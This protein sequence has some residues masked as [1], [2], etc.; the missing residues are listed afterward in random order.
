VSEHERPIAIHASGLGKKFDIYGHPSDL[1]KEVLT[2]RQRHSEYWALREITFDVLQG[3]VVG[4]IGKNGAGKSTLLKILTGTLEKT[5]GELDINGRV[6]AI[7]ELGTGFH[8]E[9]SGRENVYFNGLFLG[10]SRREIDTKIESIV[11]FAGLEEF[12]DQP[13]RTYSSGMQARLAFSTAIAVEPDILIVDEALAVGDVRFQKKC[14]SYF[15]SLRESGRTIVF[16][17]HSTDTI[18]MICDRAIY[19]AE[20]VVRAHGPARNVTGLYLKDSLGGHPAMEGEAPTSQNVAKYRYGT[21]EA[22]IVDFAVK[23]TA[24][25]RVTMLTTGE[26]YTFYCRVTCNREAIDGL[27]VGVSVQT[28]QGVRLFAMNP[29]LARVKPPRVRLAECLEVEISVTLWLAPGD[30]FVTFGAWAAGE[31]GHFD[32]VVDALHITVVGDTSLSA[33]LVNMEPVYRMAVHHP[34]ID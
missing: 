3:E 29:I 33:S 10:M 2:G 6:A 9:F 12:I 4:I 15:E 31:P 21:G 32:R 27:N 22:R 16:V 17:S 28:V 8:P 26:R 24:E 13:L 20:G 1:L 14:F 34:A 7:L 19:L 11:E 25:N 23:D 5:Y 18:D 30:F